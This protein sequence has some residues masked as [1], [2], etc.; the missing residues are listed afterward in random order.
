MGEP[1]N[2]SA[3]GRITVKRERLRG[4]STSTSVGILTMDDN[5]YRPKLI[6]AVSSERFATYR[7]LAANAGPPAMNYASRSSHGSGG[8]TTGT[9]DNAPEATSPPSQYEI[10]YT[11]AQAA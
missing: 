9:A 4:G 5:D 10:I 11:T 1:E 6:K 8:S 2:E 7:R 3:P